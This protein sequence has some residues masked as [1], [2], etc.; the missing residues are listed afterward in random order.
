MIFTFTDYGYSGLYLG[1]VEAAIASIAPSEKVIHLVNDAPRQNP[2]AS[3]YLLSAY[4]SDLV[5][6]SILCC[7]VD[8]GVGSDRD[9]PVMLKPHRFGGEET[10]RVYWMAIHH[11]RSSAHN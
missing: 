3:A 9:K 10:M 1:Q 11:I 4:S 7:V 8:P 5:E 6:G 2:K